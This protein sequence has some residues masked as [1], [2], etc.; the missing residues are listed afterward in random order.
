MSLRPPSTSPSTS[1][2]PPNVN[3]S[4]TPKTNSRASLG[5]SIRPAPINLGNAPISPRPGAGRPTSELL[6]GTGMFQTPE[7]EAIDQWF[8]NL[9]NYEATLEDMAAA[10]LDVNFKEE[11]G[12]IEQWFRVLSEAERTAALYSLLQHSTQ[13][14]IRFFI[15]VLQQMARADPMTALLSPNAGGSMQSQMEQKLAQMG[16]KSPALGKSAG[17]PAS[18]STRGTFGSTGSALH[19]QSLAVLESTPSSA[20]LSPDSAANT[21]RGEVISVG[22]GGSTE[23]ATM[24]AHHRAKLKANAAHR[25]SAPPVSG[26]AGDRSGVVW[27][28]QLSQVAERSGDG[29]STGSGSSSPTQELTIP[30]SISGGIAAASNGTT[31]SRPKST[32][33]SGLLRSPRLSSDVVVDNDPA[34][35]QEIKLTPNIGGNAG[36][37]LSPM[38]GGNWA[39]MVNTPLVPLFN[40]NNREEGQTLDAAAAKLSTWQMGNSG[41]RFSLDD[42]KKFRRPTKVGSDANNAVYGDD[43]TPISRARTGAPGNNSGNNWNNNSNA[44]AAMRSPALSSVSSGR[45][46]SDGGAGDGGFG[47]PSPAANMQGLAAL[48]AMNLPLQQQMNMLAQMQQG[49]GVNGLNGLQGLNGMQGMNG[50]GGMAVGGINPLMQGMMGTLTPEAQAQLLAAQMFMQPGAFGMGAAGL[51]G[52]GMMNA[53]GVGGQRNASHG[54]TGR[55]GM[56]S[57][58]SAN[59][60]DGGSSVSGGGVKVGSGG[61]GDKGA[62]DD[63][64][65]QLLE[66]LPAWLRKLRLHKYT[67]LFEKMNWRDLVVMDEADLEKM[68]VAALGARRKM[69]KTFEVVRAKMGLEMPPGKSGATEGEGDE[70]VA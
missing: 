21:S 41:G 27:G 1:P 26:M 4:G 60:R 39:S 50:V 66:D 32:D 8:E 22:G 65:P 44:G 7:A 19:R 34:N 49:M 5:P 9:Q 54:R 63:V 45:F 59:G 17:P 11:L 40:N 16:L 70:E 15:T 35:E 30:S 43:G 57:G 46:G 48:Q 12:A 69:V 25:I 20:F 31:S 28:G 47:M 62:D 3:G 67:P 2:A 68:G 18:P 10:S 52:L 38:V 33:F 23:A 58:K 36:N 37:M 55:Q 42:A 24:L 53:G 51:G 56:G 14:Q 13:V 29:N 61:A 64:D 6:S